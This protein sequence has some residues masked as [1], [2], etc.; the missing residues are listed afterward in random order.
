VDSQKDKGTT[1]HITLPRG[2][3]NDAA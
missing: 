2:A 3:A 1:F